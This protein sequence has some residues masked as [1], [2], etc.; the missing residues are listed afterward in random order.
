M[1]PHQSFLPADTP[2]ATRHFNY[3]LVIGIF[4]L[5][6]FLGAAYISRLSDSI[7]RKN[8]IMI[9]LFGSLVGYVITIASL[10]ADSLWLLVLGRAITGFTAGNQPI[11]QAAMI[12]ASRDDAEKAR[13]MGFIVAGISAGLVGGPIIGGV[14]SDKSALG[15]VASIN[16]PF[17]CALALVVITI[18]L[19]RLFFH[20]VREHKEQLRIR[21]Q[22]IFL[23]LWKLREHPIVLKISLVFFFFQFAN[24]TFYIF[25]DNYLTSRFQIGLFGTSMAMMVLGIALATS[26]SL[27]VAPAQKHLSKRQIVIG[28]ICIMIIGALL[29]ALAPQPVYCYFLIFVYYFGFGIAYPTIL[30]IFSAS[31]GDNEQG[32][33]MGITVAL[34]TLA[35]GIT[36]FLGGELMSIDIRS[37]FFV[38][39][40]A[41]VL[42]LVLLFVT[43]NRPEELRRITR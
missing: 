25:M 18:I 22:D 3:G 23:S 27:L 32:W 39:C 15:D 17:Y 37:P 33:V 5:S 7:G 1:D 41:A 10:F 4:F 35:A 16:L 40:A 26:S 30:G 19:V 31:V 29:Y 43:W 6:W 24:V 36:S 13:N 2:G 21:P 11:A 38:S 42:A 20:D 28:M 8:A 12:D 14:L 34:F 9:C